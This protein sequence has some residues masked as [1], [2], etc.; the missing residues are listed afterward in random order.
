MKQYR[1]ARRETG[2]YPMGMT[3]T[4]EGVHFSVAAQGTELKLLF[5]RNDE[6][7][8]L[9]TF[10]FPEKEKRG[11]VF[12]VTILGDDFTGISYC[13]EIDGKRFSDPYGRA[14][15]DK[16]CWGDLERA[17]VLSKSP[18][19]FKAFDWGQ[20]KRPLIPYEDSVVYRIHV[21]GFTMH[22]SS[23]TRNKGTFRA[24]EEKIPYL[25]ELGITTVELM[26]VYEFQEVIL[27]EIV[28]G[29]PYGVDKPTG[30][31]NYW[32]YTSGFYFTPKASYVSDNKETPA[33]ELKNLVKAL[34][35]EGIE[36]ITELYFS[37]KESPT[38]VLDAVRFWAEEFHLDGI[39]LVGFPPLD[40]IGRD[41][42]L[43]GL[44]LWA[45]SWGDIP[46]KGFKYLAEY[47]DSYQTDMRRVLKGDEEQMK[48]LVFRTRN[49]PSDRGMIQ[50]MAN[51]NGF[52]M[53][54]MVSYDT[55]HNEAN[56]ESNL[57][58][59]PYNYS[60]NCGTEGPTRKKKVVELRKK[61][62]RNAFL[63]LLL[64]QGTPLFMAGDEFGNTQSG[65]NNAYCQDND[66][67][68]LNW[69][70][71]KTNRDLFEFVKAVI[72]FRKAHPVFHRREEAKNMDYLACGVPDV[73][74]HG[75]KPWYPEYENFR[76]QL[77]ILYWG[78]YARKADGTADNHFYTAY[79]LH[80][81]PHS[82][83]LPN[84]PKKHQWHVVFHTDKQEENGKYE[85]GNEPVLEGKSFPVPPRTIVVFIG[86]K[87][88]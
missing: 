46:V 44:K 20:D 72:A 41:P 63:L 65:N 47:N 78:D 74:Y 39:H 82:F 28:Q 7:E 43:K 12:S 59:N 22:S 61:Q 17:A 70:L 8:P 69:N 66:I 26:P 52:T 51:T 73:S 75:V 30:K 29:S 38:F 48:N 32:G 10:L 36:L 21:R 35:K 68:W 88:D 83:D 86:K 76:R 33:L 84:L 9:C 2:Y 67:S 1:I 81:E 24:I 14:F 50:Y 64:S 25:K 56:G 4:G 62:L 42:Y 55:K 13:Y 5:F 53:M 80:W 37:G 34:H 40:L 79:N 58:G 18:V 71:L 87:D 31:I 54:D 6:K 57:D 23:G 15:T 19:T 49:N 77:G 85:E 16:N 60:W 11:E 3:K 27:P 45:D